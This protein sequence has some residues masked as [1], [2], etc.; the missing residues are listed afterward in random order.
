MWD[1]RGDRAATLDSYRNAREIYARLIKQHPEDSEIPLRLAK[2]DWL[3]GREWARGGQSA[4]ALLSYQSALSILEQLRS[5]HPG[6]SAILTEL[7]KIYRVMSTLQD[8]REARESLQKFEAIQE[9]LYQGSGQSRIE[10]AIGY[11][12]LGNDLRWAGNRV[13]A[14]KWLQKGLSIAARLRAEI[15]RKTPRYI[16]SWLSAISASATF[17]AGQAGRRKRS[18]IIKRRSRFGFGSC[19]NCPKTTGLRI[20]SSGR[21][22]VWGLLN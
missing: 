12:Q 16:S 11:N 17:S 14:L 7:A 22:K 6:R 10:V 18:S 13:E 15:G 3:V 5:K 21:A 8:P 19:A 9:K 1:Y 4:N 2:T 20:I